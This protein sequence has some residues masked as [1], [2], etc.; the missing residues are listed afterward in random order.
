[1]LGDN[2]HKKTTQRKDNIQYYVNTKPH[3]PFETF[4]ERKEIQIKLP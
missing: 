2:R 3:G 4:L 1:M